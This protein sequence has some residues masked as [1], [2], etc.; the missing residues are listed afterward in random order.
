MSPQTR[1]RAR[2]FLALVYESQGILNPQGFAATCYTPTHGPQRYARGPFF[3]TAMH[4]SGTAL[5]ARDPRQTPAFVRS[6]RLSPRAAASLGFP[7]APRPVLFPK[8]VARVDISQNK[9]TAVYEQGRAPASPEGSVDVV[10]SVP[11]IINN[12]SLEVTWNNILDGSTGV[13]ER[14]VLSQLGGGKGPGHARAMRNS[15]GRW[16]FEVSA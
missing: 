8:L 15:A 12:H 11:R 16:Q 5:L 6:T 1:P 9:V 14:I 4:G 13:A 10:F 3:I 2:L 7:L